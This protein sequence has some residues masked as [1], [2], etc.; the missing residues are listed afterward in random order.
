MDGL[1]VLLMKII[2]DLVPNDSS[3]LYRYEIVNSDG[4]GI[5]TYT[6]LKYAPD[7]LAQVPTPVNAAY[8]KICMA[9][10]RKL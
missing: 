9:I 2:K 6:Y 8:L 4:T 3:K 7:M 10:Q 5:G 1:G